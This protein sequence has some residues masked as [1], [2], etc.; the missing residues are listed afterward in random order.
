MTPTL[1]ARRRR[2][3]GYTLIEVVIASAIGLFVM[4][5]LTSIVLTT[6]L[7]ANTATSRVEASGQI[8]N[9]QLRA[10]DD[11]ALSQ[12]PIPPGCGSAAASPCTFQAITLQGSRMPNQE[13][14][15]AAGYQVTYAWDPATKVVTRQT[16]GASRQT[17]SNVT[18]YSWYVDSASHPSVVISMTVTVGFYNTSYSQSQTMRFYPRVT[19]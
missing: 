13:A 16:G 2:Q 7:A 3:A 1:A 18:A 11:F 12:A 14:V 19:S 17:A 9:F 10:Y 15:A 4:G 6:V 5:S 8:R